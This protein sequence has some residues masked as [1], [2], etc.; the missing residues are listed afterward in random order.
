MPNAN[1]NAP[2]PILRHAGFTEQCGTFTPEDDGP[3]ELWIGSRASDERIARLAARHGFDT[4]AL[5]YFARKS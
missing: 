5:I 1:F 3:P 4:R 2:G